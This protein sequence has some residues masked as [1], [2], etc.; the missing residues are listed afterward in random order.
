MPTGETHKVFVASEMANSLTSMPKATQER[1]AHDE[2]LGHALS[3]TMYVPNAKMAR[4]T[5][6]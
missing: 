5:P 4:M 2:N 6:M 1:Y 3:G